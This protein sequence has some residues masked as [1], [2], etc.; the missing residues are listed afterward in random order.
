MSLVH[1]FTHFSLKFTLIY[2]VTFEFILSGFQY[3]N[4]SGLNADCT[5]EYLKWPLKKYTLIL[6]SS[7]FKTTVNNK[8]HW[9][10]VRSSFFFLFVW[11]KSFLLNKHVTHTYTHAHTLTHSPTLLCRPSLTTFTSSHRMRSRPQCLILERVLT[12]NT[13]RMMRATNTRKPRTIAMACRNKSTQR[14]WAGLTSMS[15]QSKQD[16]AKP[17]PPQWT[18]LNSQFTKIPPKLNWNVC[19]YPQTTQMNHLA[20]RAQSIQN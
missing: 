20:Y 6:I 3:V 15:P 16:S 8:L 5:N 19:H 13:S 10:D 14:Q 11:A 7:Q 1:Q 18:M 2:L 17:T 12:A 9:L 4:F